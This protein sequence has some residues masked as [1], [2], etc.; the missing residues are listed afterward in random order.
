MQKNIKFTF[1]TPIKEI[2]KEA[3]DAI[4]NG[5]NDESFDVSLKYSKHDFTYNLA[6][7][8]LVNMLGRWYRDSTSDKI[9]RW[10]EDFMTIDTCPECNGQRL[11]KESL[12]FKLAEKNIADLA[13]MDISELTHWM[14]ELDQHLSERQNAIAKEVL[15]EIRLRLGFLLHVGLDYLNLN[16]PARTLSGGESQRIRLATQIGSQLTGITYILD[17]P[18]IGLHQRDNQKLIEA[19]RDLSEIGN[20]VL[21]VEHDKDIMLASDYLIDL[22]ARCWKTWRRV[23]RT[24]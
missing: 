10:A 23:G 18:S 2:P 19:L 4:L 5:G 14:N 7:E 6:Y 22:G 17:E 12:H 20:T 8:G 11:K 9:R 3:L 21:V 13:E 1:A 16:R 15:K 24:G